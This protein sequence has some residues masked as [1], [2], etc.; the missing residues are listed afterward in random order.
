MQSPRTAA[1][2]FATTAS[3]TLRA[4]WHSITDEMKALEEENNRI[5][6]DAYGLQDELTAQ[7]PIE[8]ITL[9]CN[10]AYRYGVKGTE[11]GHRPI[12]WPTSSAPPKHPVLSRFRKS[13]WKAPWKP[14]LIVRYVWSY[15]PDFAL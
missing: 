14:I 12:C 7:V 10:P 15:F 2:R 5:F 3:D 6:I 9:A 8:E 4:F 13:R 11:G 1:M